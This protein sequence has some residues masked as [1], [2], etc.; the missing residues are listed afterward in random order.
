MVKY[1]LLILVL[2][3]GVITTKGQS[4]AE[5]DSLLYLEV[6]FDLDSYRLRQGERA[7]VDSLLEVAPV[8]VLKGLEIFGHTDSL[9]DI[10]YN[11]RLSRKR[12]QSILN[13]LI[14]RGVDPV[15]VKTDYYG[16][17][18]PKYDNGPDS[19]FRNRRCEIFFSIDRSLL[20]RPE[21]KLVDLKPSKGDK[22][23]IPNLNFVGNQPIPVSESY[24]SLMDLV[25]LVRKYPNMRLELQGHVCCGDDYELS[26]ERARTVYNFLRANGVSKSRMSYEGFSNTRPLFPERSDEEKA[27]NRR[28]EVMILNNPGEVVEP[29]G[30]DRIIDIQAPVL[31]IRFFPGKTRT[32]P[33]TAFMMGLIADMIKESDGLYYEFLL[34]D[35]IGNDNLSSSRAASLKRKFQDLGLSKKKYNV[36]KM[37]RPKGMPILENDNYIYVKITKG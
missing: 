4:D 14:Y 17:E 20:P 36:R 9:A 32:P 5:G 21:Q 28:V 26:L 2:S 30:E 33:S 31:N 1:I 23:R 29:T 25:D 24:T 15:N 19:R 10:D 6:H 8:A 13:Y 7:K 12:V 18:R 35:N 34:Y 3:L 27:L 16:E 11:R 37:Q 22:I